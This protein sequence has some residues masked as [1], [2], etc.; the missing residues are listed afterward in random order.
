[1]DASVR[2]AFRQHWPATGVCKGFLGIHPPLKARLRPDY[3][4]GYGKRY[5]GGVPRSCISLLAR[6]ATFGIGNEEK[7]RRRPIMEDRSGGQHRLPSQRT[8][9]D[10][11]NRCRYRGPPSGTQRAGH[12]SCLARD[13]GTQLQERCLRSQSVDAASSRL[14]TGR[15]L[16]PQLGTSSPSNGAYCW[17]P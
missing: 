4:A 1:M 5:S 13:V 2:I 10:A 3:L 15:S 9:G 6:P 14:F 7:I 8:A 16:K 12:L 11:R 17:P